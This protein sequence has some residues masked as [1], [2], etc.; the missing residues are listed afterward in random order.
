MGTFGIRFPIVIQY[1]IAYMYVSHSQM[2][3]PISSSC[4]NAC[5]MTEGAPLHLRKGNVWSASSSSRS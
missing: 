4:R 3:Q 1:R 2:G 5:P